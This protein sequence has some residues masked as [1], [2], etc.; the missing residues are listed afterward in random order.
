MKNKTVEALNH[1][2]HVEIGDGWDD[3]NDNDDKNSRHEFEVLK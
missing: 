2:S 1:Y 3:G